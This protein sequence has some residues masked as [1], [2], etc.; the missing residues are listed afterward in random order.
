MV[1]AVDPNQI[2]YKEGTCQT[3]YQEGETYIEGQTYIYD[4]TRNVQKGINQ[5]VNLSDNGYTKVTWTID[6]VSGSLEN[7]KNAY[8]T[9]EKIIGEFTITIADNSSA[10]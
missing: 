1:G 5:A 8:A 6:L 10:S 2:V 4:T 9:E 3:L 7:V